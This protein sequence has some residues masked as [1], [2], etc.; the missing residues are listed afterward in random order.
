MQSLLILYTLDHMPSFS[1]LSN[2]LR[3]LLPFWK[4]ESR[5]STISI[6]IKFCS[7]VDNV[8][9]NTS[10]ILYYKCI[11]VATIPRDQS[12]Y[13]TQFNYLHITQLTSFLNIVAGDKP[14]NIK[15]DFSEKCKKVKIVEL[16]NNSFIYSFLG[17]NF[18][19]LSNL[20]FSLSK[21]WCDPDKERPMYMDY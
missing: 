5:D 13:E 16:E 20:V 18:E 4:S 19:I 11:C 2:L 12:C 17:I 9:E 1:L 3:P 7:K 21:Q 8:N 14:K 10:L 6:L 15:L